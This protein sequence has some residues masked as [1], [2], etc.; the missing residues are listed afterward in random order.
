[1]KF[2]HRAAQLEEGYPA[3]GNM[4]RTISM[5]SWGTL[6]FEHGPLTPRLSQLASGF[7]LLLEELEI[8]D[9][10]VGIDETLRHSPTLLRSDP[11]EG[12]TLD[13]SL[14]LLPF[15][16]D[17]GTHVA[18]FRPIARAGIVETR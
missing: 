2:A 16:P 3:R 13:A 11:P 4:T 5:M 9:C 10:I 15:S 17:L 12:R 14:A 6:K 8:P 18:I 7:Q 1:M